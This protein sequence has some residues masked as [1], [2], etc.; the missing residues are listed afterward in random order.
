M[1]RQRLV[2]DADDNGQFFLCVQDG[3]LSVG[4]APGNAETVFRNL[5]VVRIH[6]EVEVDETVVVARSASPTTG[7]S[8]SEKELHPGQ[9]VHAGRS[10]VSLMAARTDPGPTAT[11]GAVP[12]PSPQVSV[13]RRLVVIDGA[14]LHRSFA[15]PSVGI[16][17]IGN[18][19]KHA[20]LVLHDLYVA[21]VHCEL[22]VEGDRLLVTHKE[23]ARGTLING[24]KIT[25][26]AREL[27]LGDI[28]RVGNSHLRY[29]L[30]VGEVRPGSE[31]MD[32]RETVAVKADE[33]EPEIETTGSGQQAALPPSPLDA[34]LKLKNQIVGAYQLGELIGRGHSSLSFQ[35]QHRQTNQ[36][37]SMKVLAPNYPHSDAELQNFVRALKVI[38]P[39]RHPHLV[40]LV[41][42]GKAGPCYWIAREYVEGTSL[43]VLI[44]RYDRDNPPSWKRACR[45]AIHLGKVLEFL[46]QHQVWPGNLTPPNVLIETGTKTIRLSDILFDTAESSKAEPAHRETWLLAG[47]PYRAPEQLVP[48][49]ALDHRA[50]LY[51]LGAVLYA[52]LTGEP[53][54]TGDSPEAILKQIREGKLA[55]PSKV[56]REIPP[57]FESAV[58]KLLARRPDDRYP[59]AG[60]LLA[61][62]EPIAYM[63][64]IKV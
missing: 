6:C 42:A 55:K 8:P 33:S 3:T 16:V 36:A 2:I 60:E 58:L 54:C 32:R 61:V 31:P 53:P 15:L 64:E 43:A 52:L 1:P 63:H 7:A 11:A 9:T 49:E 40:P 62:V 28:L 19:Q 20:S 46:D 10:R 24:Q 41:A 23:G 35:A 13:N 38:G 25:A 14:D 27:R 21:R 30:G 59:H 17:T 50:A 48:G 18:S 4:A 37:V 45:A 34:L 5:R 47:L 12:A 22:Q 57:P 26:P 56:V 44:E 39:L 29:E 51:A